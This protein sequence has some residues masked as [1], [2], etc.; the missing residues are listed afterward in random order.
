MSRTTR[1]L[2]LAGTGAW[3]IVGVWIALHPAR[4][5]VVPSPS[6]AR[7]V[8][9]A[10]GLGPIPVWVFVLLVVGLHLLF[11]AALRTRWVVFAWLLGLQGLLGCLYFAGGLTAPP[12]VPLPL[13]APY[14]VR[15]ATEIVAQWWGL[16]ALAAFLAVAILLD[17]TVVRQSEAEAAVAA[18]RDPAQE[19]AVP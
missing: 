2:T 6:I 16:V 9:F 7:S 19:R 3:L 14:Q 4:G 15:W 5:F 1:L 18:S 8:G 13:R 11:A 12:F 17:R 10:I